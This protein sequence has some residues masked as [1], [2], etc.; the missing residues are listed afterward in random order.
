MRAENNYGDD[1]TQNRITMISFQGNDNFGKAR[2][3]IT[4]NTCAFRMRRFVL[5]LALSLSLSLFHLTFNQE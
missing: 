1:K 4:M 5:S 2:T 3:P